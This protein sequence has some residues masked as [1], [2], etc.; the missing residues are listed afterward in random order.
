MKRTSGGAG[1][2]H[3]GNGQDIDE[4]VSFGDVF[5]NKSS[6]GDGLK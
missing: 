3:V 6:T 2:Y 1:A 4:N 5:L